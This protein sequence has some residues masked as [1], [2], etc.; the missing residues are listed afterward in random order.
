M[1]AWLRNSTAT[2]DHLI[3]TS[4]STTIAMVD[5]GTKS[6][7]QTGTFDC[8]FVLLRNACNFEDNIFL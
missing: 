5:L 8:H 3:D 7:V 2:Y 1:V 6:Q 4:F